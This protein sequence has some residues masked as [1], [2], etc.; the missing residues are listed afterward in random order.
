M[1]RGRE[2]W[3][4]GEME[5]GMD[6]WKDGGREGGIV[7]RCEGR[8]MAMEN[9]KGTQT[10]LIHT[11]TRIHTHAPMQEQTYTNMHTHMA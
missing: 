11:H 10:G 6:G 2:G 8:S 4:D 7:C 3:R 9:C 5:G 1:E